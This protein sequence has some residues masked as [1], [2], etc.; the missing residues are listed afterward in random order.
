MAAVKDEIERTPAMAL[1]IMPAELRE[2][3]VTYIIGM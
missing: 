3:D 1:D 2:E